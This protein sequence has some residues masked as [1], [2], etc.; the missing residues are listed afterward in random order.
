MTQEGAVH[1]EVG[2]EGVVQVGGVLV[3]GR[4]C[5]R[6]CRR[7]DVDHANA[8]AQVL[9]LV[10][11][12]IQVDGAG[13]GNEL[14]VL[15][16]DAARHIKVMVGREVAL[17][18]LGVREADELVDGEP[19]L[20]LAE[21]AEAELGIAHIGVDSL[22]VEPVA[23]VEQGGG[24]VKVMQGHI[25]LDAILFAAGEQLVVVLNALGEGLGIVAVGEDAGPGDG[26]TDGVE[27]ML[28]RKADILLVAVVEITGRV[29]QKATL[30]DKVIVPHGLTLACHLRGAFRLV[31]GG[32]GAP[33]KALR[34]LLYAV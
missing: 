30:G 6:I 25:G 23:L 26:H 20:D 10:K 34:Q 9:G 3:G 12:L 18:V 15:A 17:D 2:V 22:A 29:G 32:C 11:I 28:G 7:Q 19:I 16:L 33:N 1:D 4:V 8:S 5:G 24:G 27:S 21:L 14:V 31:R 13:V